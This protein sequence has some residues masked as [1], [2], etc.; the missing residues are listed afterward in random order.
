MGALHPG[1]LSLIR[2]AGARAEVVVATI[3]VNP[4]QFGPSEDLGSY[5]RDLDGDLAKLGEQGVHVVFAPD[6]GE[7]YPEAFGTTVSVRG[8]TEGLCGASRPGHFDGVATVVL[9]LFNICRPDFAVFG[10]KDFQQVAVI[11]K[12]VSDLNL[13]L[14]IVAQPIVREP[15]GLAMSSRNL[16]LSQEERQRARSLSAG[17][18]EAQE[19]YDR[20][21][22]SAS[23]LLGAVRDRMSNSGVVPE[24]LELR[25]FD[26]LVRVDHAE[27][28]SVILVAARIGSTRLIDNMIL[29]RP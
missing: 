24:Y 16:R 25:G 3:F 15:D 26:D 2:E 6:P 14:T 1:H 13:D 20:G 11:R 17:L 18:R 29:R 10:E 8:V 4:T 7:M 21:E 27:R 22:R 12:L 28:P 5:P 23:L 9:K 19:R